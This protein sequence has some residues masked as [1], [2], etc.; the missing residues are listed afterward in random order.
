M[1][2]VK[3]TWWMGLIEQ[4]AEDKF[5][6][7]KKCEDFIAIYAFG[8]DYYWAWINGKPVKMESKM[9]EKLRQLLKAKNDAEEAYHAHRGEHLLKREADEQIQWDIL[10]QQLWNQHLVTKDAYLAAIKEATKEA[11]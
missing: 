1:H 2:T 11:A 4:S 6:T 9:T 5:D 8:R 7:V 10:D 3:I